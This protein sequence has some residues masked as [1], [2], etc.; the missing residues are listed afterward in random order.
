MRISRH[1]G[2]SS[3]PFKEADGTI[4]SSI[5]FSL[6][7]GTNNAKL[8]VDPSSAMSK[9]F[10][11]RY[12]PTSPSQS[13]NHSLS[14][15]DTSLSGPSSVSSP[16]RRPAPFQLHYYLHKTQ[17]VVAHD[18]RSYVLWDIRE[19]PCNAQAVLH[20]PHQIPRDIW[21]APATNP[22]V[23]ALNVV[24][25]YPRPWGLVVSASS[26]R[27]TAGVTVGDVLGAIYNYVHNQ[28]ISK[29]E[30]NALPSKQQTRVLEAYEKR[31]KQAKTARATT[32]NPSTSSSRTN[33]ASSSGNMREAVK[34][35]DTFL[36]HT[37][38]AGLEVSPDHG[39]TV[40]LSVKRPN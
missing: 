35:V 27:A 18:M 19:Q 23:K 31:Q 40:I 4:S 1:N 29:S 16:V 25:E 37:L 39:H 2:A 14:S 15:G 28:S 30:F 6:F 33:P 9:P 24:C 20:L 5:S 8:S 32:A 36:L 10:Q 3:P 17:D 38:F 22:P 12:P 21:E 13:S 11:Y 26:S 34:L 7:L